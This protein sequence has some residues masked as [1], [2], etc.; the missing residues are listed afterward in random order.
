[1]SLVIVWGNIF[2]T[3]NHVPM[4]D[5]GIEQDRVTPFF[6]TTVLQQKRMEF[7]M[8]VRLVFTALVSTLTYE[9]LLKSGFIVQLCVPGESDFII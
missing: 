1:M 8:L 7:F 6:D 5:H 9:V 4:N 3:M 2:L